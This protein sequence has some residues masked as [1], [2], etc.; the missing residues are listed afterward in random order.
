[1]QTPCSQSG[2]ADRICVFIVNWNRKDDLE[3]LLASLYEALALFRDKQ[4]GLP[5]DIVVLDNASTDGSVDLLEE[6]HPNV[7]IVRNA[8]NTGGAGGFA[9]GMEY[10]RDHGYSYLWILDNDVVLVG[11]PL[12]PLLDVMRRE[13]GAGLVGSCI[14]HKDNPD[15]VS[16]AG[17]RIG[18]NSYPKPVCMNVKRSACGESRVFDVDY[19]A[20]CSALIRV[21]VIEYCGVFDRDYFLMWDDMD[22]GYRIKRR[23]FGVYATTASMVIHP[24]FSERMPSL[25]LE[26]YARRNHMRFV[27]RNYRGL[28]KLALL[29]YLNAIV[30]AR[31][32]KLSF[33]G[34]PDIVQALKYARED[35]WNNAFGQRRDLHNGG[36]R[37]GGVALL[38]F[39]EIDW[40][41]ASKV[42]VMP[43]FPVPLLRK[44]LGAL[45][46]GARVEI[47]ATRKHFPFI[48]S[49]FP[50]Y[51]CKILGGMRPYRD[52]LKEK[53]SIV[54][55]PAWV[56][57]P[58][59][60]AQNGGTYAVDENMRARRLRGRSLP[61][62]AARK[63][64]RGLV[65][66]GA[67]GRGFGYT[68]F[69]QPRRM[70]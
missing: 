11:D 26:Y 17:A 47:H 15:F 13:T 22:W 39:E 2:D 4:P 46:K 67:A 65:Y 6:R 70:T 50:D 58:I 20:A 16:E 43:N 63:L 45:P 8:V 53:D 24:G 57:P 59:L 10:A 35:F 48:D 21:E 55:L 29:A 9:Q 68:F 28:R 33:L 49:A 30:A 19:V 56:I 66:L 40:E 25:F 44:M 34:R 51:H 42:H 54:L 18:W 60:I 5:V 38:P 52:I 23:G 27:S 3:K 36:A 31:I 1:M 64:L 41:G 69:R 14:L 12:T 61:M 37:R 7:A 62:G 32:A